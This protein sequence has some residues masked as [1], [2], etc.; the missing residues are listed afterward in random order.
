[1]DSPTGPVLS[2]PK[3]QVRGV[4]RLSRRS[5]LIDDGRRAAVQDDERHGAPDIAEERRSAGHIR[6]GYPAPHPEFIDDAGIHHKGD[7]REVL[8]K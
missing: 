3:Q 5:G 4:P 1:M 6:A 8:A 2:R 7:R